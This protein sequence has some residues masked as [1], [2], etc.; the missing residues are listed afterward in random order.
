MGVQQA[1]QD[2]VDEEALDSVLALGEVAVIE[3]RP[4]DRDVVGQLPRARRW[5]TGEA[6]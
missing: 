1:D 4:D 2:E 6:D 3:E 5:L